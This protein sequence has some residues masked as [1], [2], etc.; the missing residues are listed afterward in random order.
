VTK[1]SEK[2]EAIQEDTEKANKE[3]CQ[4]S[5]SKGDDRQVSSYALPYGRTGHYE[6]AFH[7][8]LRQEGDLTEV[9]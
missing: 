1:E 2:Y 9:H 6:S 3:S 4:Y 8:V 7:L 5:Q